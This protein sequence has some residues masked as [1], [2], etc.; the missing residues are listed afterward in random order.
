[1]H[2]KRGKKSVRKRGKRFG[3]TVETLTFATRTKNGVEKRKK[4]RRA[5]QKRGERKRGAGGENNN[6]E[7]KMGTRDKR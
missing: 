5:E 7:C 3:E 6:F 1:L 2:Q 4:R